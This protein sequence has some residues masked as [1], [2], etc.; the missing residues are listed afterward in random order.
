M[1]GIHSNTIQ[2]HVAIKVDQNW[3]FLL[4]QRSN[5]R[6]VYPNVW[7]VITGRIEVDETAINAAI[8]ELGE[9]TGIYNYDGLYTIPYIA[10]FFDPNIDKIS[11]VPVFGIILVNKPVI[12]LSDEHQNYQWVDY[13]ECTSILPIP[14][15]REGTRIFRDFILSIDDRSNFNYNSEN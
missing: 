5:E 12:I 8:R 7:Q 13:E 1:P 14:S 2:L 9:E 10:S 4:L 3:E 6:D 15:H 11:L